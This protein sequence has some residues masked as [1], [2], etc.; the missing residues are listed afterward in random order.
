MP[1][2]S[3]PY[4]T[5][6]AAA[7]AKYGGRYLARVGAIEPL[8]GSWRPERIIIV[9]FPSLERAR[10]WYR[11]P[12]YAFALEAREKALTRDLTLLDGVVDTA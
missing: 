6:A 5:R 2:P 11:S 4:R 9:E 1:M 12:E 8:E 10:A 3:R 7:I